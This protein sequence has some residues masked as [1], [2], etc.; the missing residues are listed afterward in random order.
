MYLIKI[1]FL[2]KFNNKT[3]RKDLL[4][5]HKVNDFPKTRTQTKFIIYFQITFLNIP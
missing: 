1:A 3:F 5:P 4:E 2:Q